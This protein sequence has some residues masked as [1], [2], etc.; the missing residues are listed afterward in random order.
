MSG[1]VTETR[2]AWPPHGAMSAAGSEEAAEI[3][4]HIG[5]GFGLSGLG[6]ASRVAAD[7]GRPGRDEKDSGG[8]PRGVRASGAS[9]KVLGTLP[10]L[11][12]STRGANNWFN[13]APVSAAGEGA[14]TALRDAPDS[15]FAGAVRSVLAELRDNSVSEEPR[16]VLATARVPR[17]GVSVFAAGLAFAAAAEGDRVLLIE[18]NEDN[19][20]LSRLVV[21]EAPAIPL[22]LKGLRRNAYAVDTDGH[23]T[24]LVVPIETDDMAARQLHE[25]R[26]KSPLTGIRD[27]FDFVV[28][29]GAVIGEDAALM[30]ASAATDIV[31]VVP[32]QDE[33][34]ESAADAGA[35]L[36]VPSQKIA[37]IV[38]SAAPGTASAPGHA[39]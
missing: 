8:A 1:K 10:P 29:D 13:R 35:D 15:A 37:G 28:I 6:R 23:G 34:T 11:R 25:R 20:V 21:T 39:A 14:L 36:G 17:S 2:P 24:L 4:R 12:T 27:H 30:M 5:P 32:G 26:E 7:R 18:A 16:T 3:A 19:P 22:A 31:V 9:L 33:G 38:R